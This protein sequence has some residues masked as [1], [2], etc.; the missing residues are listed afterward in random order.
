M[1]RLKACV[2]TRENRGAPGKG[3]DR[4]K[5][6]FF[7]SESQGRG[8]NSYSSAEREGEQPNSKEGKNNL[9]LPSR[10]VGIKGVLQGEIARKFS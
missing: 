8:R 4:P 7:R 3:W 9:D 1:H 5:H 2:E 10:P 6:F